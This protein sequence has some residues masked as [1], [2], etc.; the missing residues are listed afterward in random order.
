MDSICEYLTRNVDIRVGGGHRLHREPVPHLEDAR[1]SC[2][3]H[4]VLETVE[5]FAVNWRD[6]STSN[7]A[8]INSW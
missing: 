8:Q 6:K 7:E 2:R 1:A 3:K 4:T 5:A